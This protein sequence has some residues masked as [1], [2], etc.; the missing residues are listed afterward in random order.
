MLLFAATTVQDFAMSARFGHRADPEPWAA[1]QKKAELGASRPALLVSSEAKAQ[2]N[3][4]RRSGK[5]Y[6]QTLFTGP[7]ANP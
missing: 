7:R 3:A 4:S 6:G 5:N 2:K 1:V